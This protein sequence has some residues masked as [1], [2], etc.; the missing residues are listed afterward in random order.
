MDTTAFTSAVIA[1][2]MLWI[3]WGVLFPRLR[4]DNFRT[5]IRNIRDD[6]FDYMWKNNLSFSNA[7]YTETRDKLND[8]LVLSNYLTAVRFILMMWFS[9]KLKHHGYH[10]S[11]LLSRSEPGALHDR[12]DQALNDA[13]NRLFY[14]VFLE[15]GKGMAFRVMM[16]LVWVIGRANN[17][18]ESAMRSSRAIAESARDFGTPSAL[19][20]GGHTAI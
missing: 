11:S 9:F 14:F 5:D 15:G 10:T 1:I 12:L 18:R 20:T 19:R 8:I 6:L 3:I 16:L 13:G 2:A 7:S 4:R 17:V